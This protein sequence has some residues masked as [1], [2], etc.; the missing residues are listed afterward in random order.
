MARYQECCC[1]YCWITLTL[2]HSQV[3]SASAHTRTH[4]YTQTYTYTCIVYTQT[5]SVIVVVFFLS[6][7]KE[8]HR[9][10]PLMYVQMLCTVVCCFVSVY[11]CAYIYILGR[12]NAGCC[13]HGHGITSLLLPP[14]V[15]VC[16]VCLTFD[17]NP[18]SSVFRIRLLYTIIQTCMASPSRSNLTAASVACFSI[19][20][21]AN[22]LR[23][24]LPLSLSLFLMC[25]CIHTRITFIL[26]PSH[27]KRL[28]YILCFVVLFWCLFIVIGLILA[29]G[30]KSR[31]Y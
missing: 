9:V 21:I 7:I 11:N 8:K 15:F 3:I 31:E 4:T 14:T 13:A 2:K 6:L 25:F 12:M 16:G 29:E 17:E 28:Y 1:R 18:G 19:S 23:F 30:K 10:F 20:A 27:A 26:K 5:V 24:H 22:V